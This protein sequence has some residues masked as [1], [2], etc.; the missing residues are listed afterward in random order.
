MLIVVLVIII[1]K[2]EIEHKTTKVLVALLIFF[3]ISMFF[4]YSTIKQQNVDLKSVEGIKTAAGIYFSWL[5]NALTNA[6]V[7]TANAIKM[8]WTPNVTL[9]NS[10]VKKK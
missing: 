2:K 1:F 5:G 9:S 7:I 3:V 6:K 8:D 10:T 4:S